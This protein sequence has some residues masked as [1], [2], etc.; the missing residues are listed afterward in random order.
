MM[1]NN[2]II[3]TG[4]K[5]SLEITIPEIS[6][7]LNRIQELEKWKI[8]IETMVHNSNKN[9]DKILELEKEN[10]DLK[11]I[12][13]ELK[14]NLDLKEKKIKESEHNKNNYISDITNLKR[15]KE[16]LE[17]KII[18]KDYEIEELK[19]DKL[20]LIN[21]NKSLNNKKIE[22]DN[23]FKPYEELFEIVTK[24]N[25]LRE[26]REKLNISLEDSIDNKFKT[27]YNFE[28][29]FELSSKIQDFYSSNK[30]V[31][32]SVDNQF[33]EDVN[34]FFKNKRIDPLDYNILY[35]PQIGDVF[36]KDSMYDPDNADRRYKYID[37]IYAPGIK[38]E[39]GKMKI[40][41]KVKGTDEE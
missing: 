41:A 40:R 26:L 13:E 19:S 31:L 39:D 36:T 1:E 32:T 12:I 6:D 15:E 5:C 21:D 17:E 2:V 29:V 37:S 11:F 35:L 33:I 38:S 22:M 9:S 18:R 24:R 30:Q 28:N 4:K 25:E 8:E 34:K 14:I 16:D 10:K 7:I 20:E 27:A 23:L 3:E